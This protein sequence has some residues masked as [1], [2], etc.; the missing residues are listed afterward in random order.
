MRQGSF[1]RRCTRDGCR[2]RVAAGARTCRCGGDTFKWSFTVDLAP[3]GAPRRQRL[4]GGFATKA[5]AVEAMSRL[6]TARVDGT[7]V[8]P[9]RRTV[10]T[11]LEDWL[12]ARSD[13]RANTARDYRVSI[14]NHIGPRIGELP[15]Q[16]LDR[17]Q[18]RGLYR[19]LADGG[20]SEKTV[21]NVHCLLYTSPSP[22]DLS[23]SRMPSSA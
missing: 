17:L 20:L 14:R 5:A 18:V 16:A 19:Q 15:L 8:E 9:S 21:H 4:S 13:I 22:R 23:T 10:R 2:S 7:Y 6:Q 1:F 11:Y 12:A 3:P